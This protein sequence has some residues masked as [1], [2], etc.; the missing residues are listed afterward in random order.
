MIQPI[1]QPIGRP[2]IPRRGF[3][4]LAPMAGRAR[5]GAMAAARPIAQPRPATAV[6]RPVGVARPAA[7]VGIESPMGIRR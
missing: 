3:Q 1:A 2:G 5:T 6:A 4:R 7:G